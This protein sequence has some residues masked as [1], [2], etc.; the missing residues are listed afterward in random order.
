MSQEDL[1]MNQNDGPVESEYKGNPVL[2]LNPNSRYPFSFGVSKA[3]LIL[4]YLDDIKAFVA[5]H[6]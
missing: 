6:Q 5:K 3:K 4:Q 1:D 2:T